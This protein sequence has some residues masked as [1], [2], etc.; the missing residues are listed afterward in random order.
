MRGYIVVDINIIIF[1][2]QLIVL[3]IEPTHHARVDGHASGTQ[4]LSGR[5]QVG[6]N[7]SDDDQVVDVRAGHFDEPVG[8]NRN[9]NTARK[10][11]GE[12]SPD[13]PLAPSKLFEGIN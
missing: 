12:K 3:L 10:S 8:R 7:P 11:R 2:Q 13:F 4:R 1:R 5:C 6:D 9:C